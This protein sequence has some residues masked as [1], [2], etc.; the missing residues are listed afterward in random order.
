MSL[1]EYNGA[2]ERLAVACDHYLDLAASL[3]DVEGGRAIWPCQSCGNASFEARFETGVVGCTEE[4]CAVPSSMN[5]L[6]LV[7]YLAP[8]LDV[9]DRQGAGERF[10][11]QY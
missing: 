2:G 4:R 5:L 10:S 11:P 6:E 8:D 1:G 7:A 3:R 9:A